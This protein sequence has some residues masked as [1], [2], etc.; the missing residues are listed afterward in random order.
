MSSISERI[1]QRRKKALLMTEEIKKERQLIQENAEEAK[2]MVDDIISKIDESVTGKCNQYDE[3]FQTTE[4]AVCELL[5]REDSA[6]IAMNNRKIQIDFFN[7][8]FIKSFDALNINRELLKRLT[9]ELEDL[10][11]IHDFEKDINIKI[12][13]E[14]S[15]IDDSEN[16]DSYANKENVN[17]LNKDN[18]LNNSK[19]DKNKNL[20]NK[21][22]NNDINKDNNDSCNYI[23]G[24]KNDIEGINRV[25]NYLTENIRILKEMSNIQFKK[26]RNNEIKIEIINV[27]RNDPNKR[28]DIILLVSDKFHIKEYSPKEL[29]LRKLEGVLEECNDLTYYINTIMMEVYKVFNN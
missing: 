11:I 20:N 26:I 2:K 15:E 23:K 29:E 9:Q 27:C 14:D 8:N 16:S 7:F 22:N 19:I 6:S 4:E 13:Q 1:N 12:K 3:S 25:K 28:V 21:A 5:K 24:W 10:S 18:I 17:C